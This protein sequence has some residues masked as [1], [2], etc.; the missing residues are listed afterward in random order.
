MT[1]MLE[2]FLSA[3]VKEIIKELSDENIKYAL[4]LHRQKEL[5]ENIHGIIY[6]D[7]EICLDTIDFLDFREFFECECQLDNITQTEL[8]K[9]GLKDCVKLLKSLSILP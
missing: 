5:A 3:R 6:R 2:E 9:Q 7:R 8:Y 1:A 4:L